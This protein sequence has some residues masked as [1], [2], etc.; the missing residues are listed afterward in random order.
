MREIKVVRLRMVG[1]QEERDFVVEL[2][3]TSNKSYNCASYHV[4][5][6]SL[7]RHRVDLPTKITIRHLIKGMPQEILKY[8]N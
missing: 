6:V 5:M 2:V 4:S 1:G 8:V 7:K 3:K